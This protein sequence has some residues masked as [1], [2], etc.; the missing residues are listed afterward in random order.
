MISSGHITCL[1]AW[2]REH[3]RPL[4]WR[5]NPP[6]PY[7][8]WLSEVML[9]QTRIEAVT[10]AYRRVLE[11]CPTVEDL[12][13]LS[14]EALLKLWQ[15]LGYYSRA[16][17]LHE[18][19]RR[20]V[21]EGGFPGTWEGWR[22]LPGVGEYTAAAVGAIVL[23]ERHPAVDGNVVR[24]LS[25]LLA[26]EIS[27]LQARELLGKGMEETDSPSA[28]A[29]AWMELGEVVCIPHG[30]PRCGQCPLAEGCR[31][32]AQGEEEAY[33]PPRRRPARSRH[34][35][36]VFQILR[37]D[38]GLALRRRPARGMLAGMW[39]PPHVPGSLGV[40]GAWKA[41]SAWGIPRR[42]AKLFPV[43]ASTHLFT[44]QEWRMTNYQVRLA[45]IPPE[46]P[47]VWA[48]PREVATRFPIPSAFRFLLP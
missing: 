25:R 11:T 27:P 7:H 29:Q 9:Q 22:A 26:R 3:A 46:F 15:G 17:H 35:L 10:E 44:H 4:P 20:I 39:E 42:Q 40:S 34:S 8:V 36:T 14:Q 12:A 38:G 24:V 1:L 13:A 30:R 16:R 47:F 43:P 32:H 2:F 41:L 23:G 5:E 37:E 21:E 28:F 48:T 31:A 33:P 6:N 19:A 45:Q 18:A